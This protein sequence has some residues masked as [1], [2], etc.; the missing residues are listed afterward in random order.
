MEVRILDWPVKEEWLSVDPR[1]TVVITDSPEIAEEASAA[2]CVVIAY[3]PEISERRIPEADLILE[4]FEEVD[5]ALLEQTWCHGRGIPY[6]VATGERI[7]LQELTEEDLPELYRIY[8][9][10]E[11]TGSLQEMTGS[12]EEELQTAQAISS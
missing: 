3:I 7:Y 12:M 4:G 1:D 11:V 5:L 10:P 2:G 6:R 8:H 9:L